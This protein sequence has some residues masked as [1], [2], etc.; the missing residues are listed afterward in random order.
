M[1]FFLPHVC[2]LMGVFRIFQAL[3]DPFLRVIPVCLAGIVLKFQAEPT[4]STNWNYNLYL[5]A[6]HKTLE[7][8]IQTL[9]KVVFSID[10][11]YNFKYMFPQKHFDPES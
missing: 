6:H 5:W 3:A 9:I 11:S 1:S 7:P 8:F 2:S 10:R 4:T